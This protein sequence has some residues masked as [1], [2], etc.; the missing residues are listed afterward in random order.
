MI[1][2]MLCTV[3]HHP[4]KQK[5]KGNETLVMVDVSTI[6]TVETI[7]GVC[8]LQTPQIVYTKYAHILV[9]NYF[10]KIKIVLGVLKEFKYLLICC[11]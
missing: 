1:D 9:N 10:H 5:T 11:K 6:L 8:I 3:K 2:L 7:S 4:W